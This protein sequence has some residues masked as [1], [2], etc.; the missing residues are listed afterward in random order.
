M[1]YVVV[2][3]KYYKSQKY[4]QQIHWPKIANGMIWYV[5]VLFGLLICIVVSGT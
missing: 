5:L 4:Q 2:S 1:H 3:R